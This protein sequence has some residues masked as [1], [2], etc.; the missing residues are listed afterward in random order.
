MIVGG[1]LAVRSDSFGR[2]AHL[3]EPIN[4]L[5]GL[6]AVPPRNHHRREPPLNQRVGRLLCSKTL[7][8]STEQRA[9][10][11][12]VGGRHRRAAQESPPQGLAT[13]CIQQDRATTRP[14]NGIDD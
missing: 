6:L 3:A 2:T 8:A 14:K 9:G 5:V 4:A 1:R 10:L 13:G 12:E 7:E 11:G